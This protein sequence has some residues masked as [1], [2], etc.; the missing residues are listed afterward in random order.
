MWSLDTNDKSFT[1]IYWC[2]FIKFRILDTNYTKNNKKVV[3]K[4]T[5]RGPYSRKF[6]ID[7][8]LQAA[9]QLGM[10]KQGHTPVK[11][12]PY[13]SIPLLYQSLEAPLP[14]SIRKTPKIIPPLS[15]KEHKQE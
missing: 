1:L 2:L 5:D 13:K 6:I 8:S 7:V 9:K 10:L 11:I 14:H 12:T 3:V 15:I 4:V